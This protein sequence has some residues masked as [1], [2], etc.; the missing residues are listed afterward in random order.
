MNNAKQIINDRMWRYMTNLWC[1][2][3]YAAI[4]YDFIYDHALGD[5]LPSILVIYIALLSIFVGVKEFERWYEIRDGRH[6]G[7]IFVYG[8]TALIVGIL[9]AKIVLNKPYLFPGEVLSSYIA[10]LSIMAITR[11]SKSMKAVCELPEN[12]DL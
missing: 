11:K 1:V 6:P 5:L 4:I 8:W 12:K 2:V 9:I 3:A 7:E 10:V